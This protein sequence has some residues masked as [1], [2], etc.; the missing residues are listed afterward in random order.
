MYITVTCVCNYLHVNMYN[1]LSSVLATSGI[2]YNVKLWEPTATKEASLHDVDEVCTACIHH[3][4]AVGN[5]SV[6][7]VCSFC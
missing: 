7:R 3:C 2:D 5:C 4:V 1:A 6:Q